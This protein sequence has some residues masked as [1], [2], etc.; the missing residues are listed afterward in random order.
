[1]TIRFAC[2]HSLSVDDG[3][4]TAPVCL[5]GE[6][7]VARVTVRPPTFRG[8]VLGPHARTERLEA[9]PLNL[10]PEGPLTLNNHHG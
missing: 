10:A 8:V 3:I 2:G 4:T 9:L 7:R 5:C 6:S 1:M